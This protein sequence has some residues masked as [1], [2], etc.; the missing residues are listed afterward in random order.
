MLHTLNAHKV[1]FVFHSMSVK[2]LPME[3]TTRAQDTQSQDSGITIY[4]IVN[5]L[6]LRRIFT[7]LLL[8]Y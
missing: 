8:S 7:D 3:N 6:N 1:F 4:I 2:R 5:P